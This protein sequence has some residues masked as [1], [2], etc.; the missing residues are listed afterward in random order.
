MSKS[1]T[2]GEVG[3]ALMQSKS[4]VQVLRFWRWEYGRRHTED[5]MALFNEYWNN[6]DNLGNHPKAIG[7]DKDFI[8]YNFAPPLS[9]V[10]FDRVECEGYCRNNGYRDSA[11]IIE[12]FIAGKFKFESPALSE[13]N[14]VN[15]LR[16]FF[17]ESDKHSLAESISRESG[18]DT[19]LFYEV[20]KKIDETLGERVDASCFVVPNDAP[21]DSVSAQLEGLLSM[22]KIRT[23]ND[24]KTFIDMAKVTNGLHKLNLGER[25]QVLS[26]GGI[27]RMPPDSAT[28]KRIVGLWLWDYVHENDCTQKEAI[29][30]VSQERLDGLGLGEIYEP[31]LRYCYR[32]TKECIDQGKI[33]SFSKKRT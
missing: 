20:L 12:D 23:I 9:R 21:F 10:T 33:L 25:H 26:Q 5:N 18:I 30:A 6:V 3:Q 19:S 2:T 8:T 13:A 14:G 32:D 11:T 29:K 7:Q 15:F 27:K 16:G 24:G 17:Y 28:P 1:V 31:D 4:D 22:S